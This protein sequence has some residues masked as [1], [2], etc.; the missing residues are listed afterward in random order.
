MSPGPALRVMTYNITC[1]SAASPRTPW[2]PRR[3]AVTAQIAVGAADVVGL[4]EVLPHQLADLRAALP[5][6]DV[7]G[8]G[9]DDGGTA[10]EHGP[11]LVRSERWTIEDWGTFWLSRTPE[12][13][14]LA[15][16]TEYPRICTWARL[17]PEVPHGASIASTPPNPAATAARA[18]LTVWNV[19]LDHRREDARVLGMREV[20]AR[21]GNAAGPHVLLGDLNAWP[22]SPPLLAAGRVLRD[23][24]AGA[25]ATRPGATFHG[26]DLDRVIGT[27]R[28]DSR[29]IDHV[30]VSP[31]VRV[32]SVSAPLPAGEP[33][34]SDH[35]PVIA[36]LELTAS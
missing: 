21:M 3:G 23:A 18:G 29:R 11:L 27:A 36:D 10:G 8:V 17:R 2:S 35:L 19:H 1:D 30:L 15:P 24:W 9:R 7:V 25:P 31:G 32:T 22:G 6:Y 26:W 33:L 16:G 13:P 28:D 5:G 20:L 4:Q 14:S 34:P 12:V